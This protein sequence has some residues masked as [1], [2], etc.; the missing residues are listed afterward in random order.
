MSSEICERCGG[1]GFLVVVGEDGYSRARPCSCRVQERARLRRQAANI[2]PRYEHCTF[3]T[4]S[5]LN[6]TL[7]R[8][9]RVA[10]RVVDD[11]PGSAKGL[12]LT[13]PCGTG[14]THL[15]V[16]TLRALVEERGAWGHFVEVAQL[17][18]SLQDTFDRDA[19][20]A[21]REIMDPAV[22]CD[23]LLLDDIGVTRGTPWTREVLGLLINER[24]NRKGLTILTTNLPVVSSPQAE[25]LG[26][27]VGDRLASRLAEMCWSISI[28]GKDFRTEIKRAEFYR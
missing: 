19:E 12:L 24:Y 8:A 4:F 16:A 15:A 14:K 17:L 28:S 26:D 21:T 5:E 18:R 11:F 23:V 13:G 10:R 6:E 2:P 20:I 27:R 9:R 7:E 25:S 22:S 1:T 3:E